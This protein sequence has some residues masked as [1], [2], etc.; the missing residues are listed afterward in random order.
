MSLFDVFILSPSFVSLI[1]RCHSLW[2]LL[3]P[4]LYMNAIWNVIQQVWCF[5]LMDQCCNLN[6]LIKDHSL[7]S[8]LLA[9]FSPSQ[10]VYK[11]TLVFCDLFRNHLFFLMWQLCTYAF[12]CNPPY[13]SMIPSSSLPKNPKQ[14]SLYKL[15]IRPHC[16][17]KI[18]VQRETN[19]IWKPIH[20]PGIPA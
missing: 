11:W 5:P 6:K 9:H 15:M 3:V 20:W 16:P 14:T 8:N 2:R 7:S 1:S 18:F 13:I 4:S 12:H 19:N 17:K 10:S